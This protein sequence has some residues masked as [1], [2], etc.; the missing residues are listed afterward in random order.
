MSNMNIMGL[1]I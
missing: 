1:Q